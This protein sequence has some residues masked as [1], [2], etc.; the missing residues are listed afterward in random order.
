MTPHDDDR[1]DLSA[2]DPTR[3]DARFEGLV[4][5]T[6]RAA[7]ARRRRTAT[8]ETLRWWRPAL[9][10]AA[11]LAIAAW[12]PVLLGGADEAATPARTDPAVAL[13][14]IART[15]APPS[16]SEILSAFGASR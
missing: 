15:D 4:R 13:L 14:T 1:L 7:M 9:V 12:L 6:V 8:T 10:L 16:P 5:S 2:L 3:D 11:S